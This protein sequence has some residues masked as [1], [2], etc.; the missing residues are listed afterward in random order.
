[1][2]NPGAYKI[3]AKM[4]VQP[5]HLKTFKMLAAELVACSCAEAGNLHYSLNSGRKEPCLM[6]FTETWRD[7]EAIR[8]HNESEH[9]TRLLP[10]L[11]ELCVQEPVTE[12]YIE[13]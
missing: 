13:E 8:I 4:Q 6:V 7:K 12:I 1:M 3:I 11:L 5:E 9:F 10:Q 2:A